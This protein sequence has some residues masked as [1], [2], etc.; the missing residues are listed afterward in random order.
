MQ[1]F[2]TTKENGLMDE[3]EV[4]QNDNFN[5]DEEKISFIYE[6]LFRVSMA[7]NKLVKRIIF[8]RCI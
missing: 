7:D 4:S 3:I 8:N 1:R 6:L 2:A 5:N